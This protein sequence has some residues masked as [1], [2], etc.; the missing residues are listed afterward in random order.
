MWVSNFELTL[1]VFSITDLPTSGL[2]IWQVA[3]VA[4][5]GFKKNCRLNQENEAVI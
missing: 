5:F 3:V 4:A 1:D 2:E